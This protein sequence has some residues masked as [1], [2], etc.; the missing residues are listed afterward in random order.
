MK[1]RNVLLQLQ[2]KYR[3]GGY[4]LV[5][6]ESGRVFVFAKTLKELYKTI[7]DKKIKDEDKTVM[8]IPSPYIKHVFYFPLSIRIY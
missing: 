6:S 8:H 2:K 3:E 7:D 1:N 5:S 4:A